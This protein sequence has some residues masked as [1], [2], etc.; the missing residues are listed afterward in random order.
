MTDRPPNIVLV[1]MDD[2]GYGDL[3]CTGNTILRTPRIDSLA[4]RGVNLRHTYAASSVCSPSRAA[5]MTGRYPQRVGLPKVLFPHDGT[6]LSTWEYTLPRMLRDTGYRTAMFGKWHL[7][8]R[9]EHHPTRHGFDEYAGL[10]YSND[11]HPVEMFE[12]D[13]VTGTDVDQATLT[14]AYTD[15]AIDFVRRHADEP[16]F[17]YLAHTMPHIPLAVTDEFRDRSAGGRYGDVVE[18]LDHHVGRL[19]DTL[20][21]VGVA[22]NTLVMVTSDNGPWFEGS[23]GGLRGNKN[24]TYEGG[25]RVPFLAR[26]PGRI[27]EGTVSDVPVCLFDLLPTLAALTGGSLPA[28][29]PIDG[30][31]V[32][33]VLTG[34]SVSRPLFFFHWWTLN[35][36]REGPWKLHLDRQPRDPTRS[37]GKE[38]PQLFNLELDPAET[39][40]LRHGQPE[41]VEHL[42]ALAEDFLAEITAQR[43][44][45]EARACGRITAS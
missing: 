18:C 7:G 42:T 41:V 34:G 23:T 33:A 36:V 43:S 5:L 1:V 12:G 21:E 37:H 19:L 10:L 44:T 28:D 29:R 30:V 13:Q 6:G 45:A 27:P 40:D 26:W 11:M 35:A 20:D 39:Y 22:D 15:H 32:S 25:V 38:L 16:F 2:L 24:H 8:C 3:G 17:V 14:G 31:D 9:P 4:E